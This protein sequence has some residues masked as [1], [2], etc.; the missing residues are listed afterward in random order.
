MCHIPLFVSHFPTGLPLAA[1]IKKKPSLGHAL[2]CSIH[3]V[4]SC[5]DY[6]PLLYRDHRLLKGH[7]TPL[8]N[9][10]SKTE[11]VF[12]IEFAAMTSA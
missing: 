4:E 5:F 9:S 3:G 10:C 11:T 7:F 6:T 2:N 12:M 8:C 1:K